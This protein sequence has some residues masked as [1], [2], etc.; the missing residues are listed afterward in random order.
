MIPTLAQ[1]CAM[2]ALAYQDEGEVGGRCGWVRVATTSCS[3]SGCVAVRWQH[4]DDSIY[5]AV[6]GSNSRR[7]TLDDLKVFLG[8][9]PR[10]RMAFFERYIETTCDAQLSGGS[11]MVGGHS[12]GGLVAMAA[13]ARWNLSGLVQ[14]SPGWLVDP[15]DQERLSNL[16]ELRTGRDVVG[17]WGH[18]VPSTITLHDPEAT[19]WD[20]RKLHNIDRQMDLVQRQ[21]LGDFRLDDPRLHA[22]R[23]EHRAHKAPGTLAWMKATWERI[24]EDDLQA[25]QMAKSAMPSRKPMG[26][27]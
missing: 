16:I 14:N 22:Q 10:A 18:S 25:R 27:R 2:N 4:E 13:A 24:H 21:G 5:L 12:L 20:L 6:R 9:P 7:D 15:P 8:Q 19:L 23:I 3:D 11:L 17:V 26:R 1:A